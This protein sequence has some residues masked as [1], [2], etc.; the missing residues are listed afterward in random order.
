MPL[1]P[2]TKRIQKRRKKGQTVRAIAAAVG[3]ST[4]KVQ[5]IVSRPLFKANLVRQQEMIALRKA[6]NEQ[7][8]TAAIAKALRLCKE[9]MDA[10]KPRD[11]SAYARIAKELAQAADVQ[12]D[13]AR[14]ML[15]ARMRQE[16]EA[17]DPELERAKALLPKA[18]PPPEAD[19]EEAEVIE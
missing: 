12:G 11:A 19:A 7:D 17:L 4:S 13:A 14:L 6:K 9:A 8:A 1:D 3:V 16:E 10:K 5:R 18:L 15:G 2:L